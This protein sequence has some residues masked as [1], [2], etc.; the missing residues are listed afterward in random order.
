MVVVHVRND[1]GV[2]VMV[3]AVLDTG[4][5]DFLSL[6]IQVINHLGLH[7]AGVVDVVLAGN[8]SGR[9]N[10]YVARVLW[11]GTEQIIQIQ[12]AEGNPLLGM[13]LLLGSKVTLQVR[14][15]GAVEIEQGA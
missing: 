8:V 6:P 14:Y 9:A 11:H 4:F 5:N 12:E 10:L 15:G 2:T 1:I 3:D 13:A 7:F